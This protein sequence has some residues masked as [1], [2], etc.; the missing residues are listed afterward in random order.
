MH[1]MDMRSQRCLHR[2]N[3]LHQLADRR[4]IRHPERFP[5]DRSTGARAL[6]IEV[7]GG[8]GGISNCSCWMTDG[9]IGDELM[10]DG[11]VMRRWMLE[12]G[13]CNTGQN[14]ISQRRWELERCPVSPSRPRATIHTLQR[15]SALA[16][17]VLGGREPAH[18]VG[19]RALTLVKR[20]QARTFSRS[21]AFRLWFPAKRIHAGYRDEGLRQEQM[22]VRSCRTT[23]VHCRIRRI[24][25]DDCYS[26]RPESSR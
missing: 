1:G 15:R 24:R 7:A 5:G 20:A 16:N 2:I 13:R 25:H 12:A 11:I 26:L 4:G 3:K 14:G 6:G 18:G 23:R 22:S 21:L 19:N 8:G 10:A 9:E 17:Q